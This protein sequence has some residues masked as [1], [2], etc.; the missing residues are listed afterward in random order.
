[1]LNYDSGGPGCTGCG[2]EVVNAGVTDNAAILDTLVASSGCSAR[3]SR[4]GPRGGEALPRADAPG[5]SGAQVKQAY[6][7]VVLQAETLDL[8]R[9]ILSGASRPRSP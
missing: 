1:M 5:S 6:A 8:D 9:E 3:R 2:R 4:A 7:Q